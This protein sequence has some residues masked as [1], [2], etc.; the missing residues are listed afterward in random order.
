MNENFDAM[1]VIVRGLPGSGK[2]TLARE[3]ARSCGYLNV[4]L[5]MYFET[6]KGYVHDRSLLME[7]IEWQFR[8]ARDAVW[9]GKK[10]VVTSVFTRLAHMD[11]IVGLHDSVAFIECF[12]DF[13]ST[14]N[15]PSEVV[16]RMR[17]EWEPFEGSI[18]I[19]EGQHA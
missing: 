4:D 14:H 3:I 8:A 12:G 17:A 19:F 15:V 2:S 16:E 11:R 10:V 7:A 9:A 1:V 18:R 13:G 5:D 6:G